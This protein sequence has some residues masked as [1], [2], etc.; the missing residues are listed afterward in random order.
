LQHRNA[1]N[2]ELLLHGHDVR[3]ADIPPSEKFMFAIRDPLTRFVSA[4]NGRLRE[5]RPRYYYPWREEEKIAFAIFKTPNDLAGALSSK[6]RKLRLQAEAAMRGIGH[7]NASYS[8]WLGKP[9]TFRKRASDLYFIA[10]QESLDSNFAQL[11]R[12]L[13]LPDDLRLP[14]SDIDS[15]RTPA[16]YDIELD[17]VAQENLR[18]WYAEDLVFVELCHQLAPVVNAVAP[19]VPRRIGG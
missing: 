3:L 15:H 1:G 7:I 14:E 11:I 8:L 17:H 16:S 19:T 2:Y 9:R 5:D 10:F 6:D 12:K 4:F 13:G 18:R